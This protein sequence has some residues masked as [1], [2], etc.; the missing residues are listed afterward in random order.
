MKTIDGSPTHEMI[1]ARAYELYVARGCE[2]G[3]DMEDW[4]RAESELRGRT[5]QPM[6]AQPSTTTPATTT[7]RTRAMRAESRS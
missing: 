2:D 1:A 6:S 3:H 5:M 7:A 4:I